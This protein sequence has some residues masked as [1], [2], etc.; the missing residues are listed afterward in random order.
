MADPPRARGPSPAFAE[1]RRDS[2][3]GCGSAVETRS[4][5]RWQ[6]FGLRDDTPNL[7][8]SHSEIGRLPSEV[9]RDTLVV[10]SKSR[11]SRFEATSDPR[12][13]ATIRSRGGAMAWLRPGRTQ[14][15]GCNHLPRRSRGDERDRLSAGRD[16]RDLVVRAWPARPKRREYLR[17]AYLAEL[18]LLPSM[19]AS[20]NGPIGRSERMGCRSGASRLTV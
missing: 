7:R 5:L 11:G 2:R 1:L 10:M 16:Q 15:R 3:G 19:S 12:G 6:G 13:P 9:A 14:R 17:V 20:T 18:G 8:V 4:T